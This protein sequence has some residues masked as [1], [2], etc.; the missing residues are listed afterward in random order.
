MKFY[1]FVLVCFNEKNKKI[2]YNRFGKFQIVEVALKIKI[3]FIFNFFKYFPSF[4]IYQ[5]KFIFYI[6]RFMLCIVIFSTWHSSFWAVPSYTGKKRRN[7]RT[8]PPSTPWKTVGNSGARQ[9]AGRTSRPAP[10][11][12]PRL[13]YKIQ[14]KKI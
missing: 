8:L 12:N 14:T 9:S 4:K 6:R 13:V 1:Q 11:V 3:I 10:I 2:I 7:W 5:S